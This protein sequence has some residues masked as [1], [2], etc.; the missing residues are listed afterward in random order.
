M[1]F[2]QT[3]SVVPPSATIYQGARVLR[4]RLGDG[5]VVGNHSRVDDSALAENVRIDR[6][7]H[8]AHARLGKHSYTGMGTVI[9]HAELGAFCS[10]AWNVSVG[11]ADHDVGRVAQHSF[12]YN[13]HD[14]L[15]PAES[16][17]PYD[18]FEQPLLI[19][20]DVWLAAGVA[21]CRGVSIG[22]GCAIGAN[23]VVTRDLPPYA[24]AVGAPARV[25]R[26]RFGE[27]IVELLQRLQWW[28]WSSEAIRQHFDVLSGQPD[29]GRLRELLAEMSE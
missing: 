12:L 5:C 17:I 9:L 19:G 27:Q 13:H 25:L 1:T 18:R 16:P 15:R 7:N 22:N 8:L 10:V 21:V 28:T 20:N 23:A 11:G 2:Q 26:L 24:V 29:A 6:N 3:D 14:A 4:S